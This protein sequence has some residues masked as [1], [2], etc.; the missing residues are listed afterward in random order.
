[1]EENLTN[2]IQQIK[3]TG[4]P[5][6]KAQKITS[7]ITDGFR[8]QT[9]TLYEAYL[10]HWEVLHYMRDSYVLAAW[11]KTVQISTCLA[12]LNHKLLALAFHDRD[13]AQQA[14]QWG[15][16]AFGL[17]AEKRTHYIMD[18]YREFI[19]IDY[20]HEDLLKELF[21][22]REKYDTMSD[23]QGPYHVEV[24][25][26]HYFAPEKMILDKTGYTKE[27]IIRKDVER[28]LTALNT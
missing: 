23:N 6:L 12:L 10:L 7:I 13:C 25:P 14:W 21:E 22:I 3:E 4:N 5:A 24:F 11:N 9:L 28:I 17:C 8:N 20:D 27:K 18:R 15:M 19:T 1:M 16:E 26:Y 2:I